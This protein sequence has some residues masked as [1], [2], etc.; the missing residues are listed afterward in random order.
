[1]GITPDRAL[2]AIS[3]DRQWLAWLDEDGDWCIC[4]RD[5][6]YS[7]DYQRSLEDTGQDAREVLA[8][9][10]AERES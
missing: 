5:S 2:V 3:D 7:F 9:F 1:M 8:A 10:L 6:Q 4:G